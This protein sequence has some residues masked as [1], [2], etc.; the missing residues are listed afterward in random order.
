MPLNFILWTATHN[1]TADTEP[2]D[3]G[4]R[5]TGRNGGDT[6]LSV[7]PEGVA[8]EPGDIDGCPAMLE[9]DPGTLILTAYQRMNAGTSRGDTALVDRFRNLFFKI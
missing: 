6:K 5:V 3:I 8:F 2:F 1:C 9:F 7:G 4:I